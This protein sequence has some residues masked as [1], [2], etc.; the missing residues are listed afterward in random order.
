MTN[1]G[2]ECMKTHLV[3]LFL[4]LAFS[5]N[6]VAAADEPVLSIRQDF[7]GAGARTWELMLKEDGTVVEEGYN[8]YAHEVSSIDVVRKIRKVSPRKIQQ[9]V[10]RATELIQG[11]PEDVG[12]VLEIDPLTKVVKE[13]IFVDEETKAIRIRKNGQKLFAGWSSYEHT[14]PN[15]DTEK[16]KRAWNSIQA[17]LRG[18]DA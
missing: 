5:A 8:I 16:F 1:V 15:G 12:R 18:P 4:C 7:S 17:L 2:M 6:G 10:G 13:R 14:L 11:L 3:S 9:L